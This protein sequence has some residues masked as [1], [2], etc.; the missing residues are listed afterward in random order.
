MLISE[1]FEL[2]ENY[3]SKK[4]S[5]F[6]D[7]NSPFVIDGIHFFN[8]TI[9][10][11]KIVYLQEDFITYTYCFKNEFDFIE[12]LKKRKVKF[13]KMFKEEIEINVWFYFIKF[14]S[15]YNIES[16]KG[17]K[18]DRDSLTNNIFREKN[19]NLTLDYKLL[20]DLEN[21]DYL[22]A[23]DNDYYKDYNINEYLEEPFI[24]SG[25]PIIKRFT[26]TGGRCMLKKC[27]GIILYDYLL[28]NWFCNSCD[29]I[30]NNFNG[31]GFKIKK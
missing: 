16:I 21:N 27:D 7:I 8:N 9:R 22:K 24:T 26:F 5:L 4:D 6:W 31:F 25:L 18:I 2:I 23:I 13:V 14:D 28:H 29:C 17:I 10:V 15:V 11:V 20:H 30:E 1:I 19:N 12:D 3:F